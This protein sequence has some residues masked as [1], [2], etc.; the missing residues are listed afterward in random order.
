VSNYQF[1]RLYGHN[2]IGNITY[3]QQYRV[4]VHTQ[5]QYSYMEN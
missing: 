2:N 4:Y 1:L 3:Q 5:R